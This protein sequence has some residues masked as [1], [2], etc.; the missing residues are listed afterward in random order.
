MTRAST[1]SATASR[2]AEPPLEWTVN[3]WRQSPGRSLAALVATVA[4]AA[5]VIA[6]EPG[7]VLALTL[8]LFAAATL[9]PG[10][11]PTRCRVGGGGIA[12]RTLVGWDER[13]WEAIRRARLVD[14]G[15]LVSP[16]EKP[17][18]RDA[19]RALFLPVPPSFAGRP[20]LLRELERRL[21]AHGL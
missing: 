8:S 2:E 10:Y 20:A 21:E 18:W 14:T 16:F 19:W 3:P 1:S 12:R 13:R 6:T 9:L 11:V 5:F 17:T 4:L 15:L 7:P